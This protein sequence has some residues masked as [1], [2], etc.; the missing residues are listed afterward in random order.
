MWQGSWLQRG[1]FWLVFLASWAWLHSFWREQISH[2]TGPARWVWVTNQ[3]ERPYPTRGVFV[4]NFQVP[5]PGP[6][7]LLKVSADREYV[8]ILN[9]VVA[10]C[11][12]SRPGFRLDVY[13]VSHLLRPGP[14]T[15][16]LEVRSPIPVG[17]LLAALDLPGLG[18]NAVI[19]GR[20]FFLQQA[21]GTLAPPPV[22]WGKPPRY[23]WGYPTPLPRPRTLDQLVVEEPLPLGLAA[24]EGPYRF[25]YRPPQPVFGYLWLI[26]ASQGWV[27][28]AVGGGGENLGQLME[29]LQ[30]YTGAP[31]PLLHPEP[32]WVGQVLVVAKRAPRS[33]EVW[34]VAEAFRSGA[35]GVV[36]GKL[37][38]VPRT[39][40]SFRNPPE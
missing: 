25:V 15:L 10:G 9:G 35:P 39:G 34:P 22:D 32:Q 36:L 26:P 29:K 4:A 21:D 27:W 7:A 5:Q 2:V 16:R 20:D 11:G 28:Y 37:G 6:G 18:K 24:Q 33:L 17:G 14:N 23:P 1:V 12:W 38:P 19:S 31:E 8:A 3:L 30:P 40:W 13:D